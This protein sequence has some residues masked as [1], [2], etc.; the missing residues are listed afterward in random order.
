[1]GG[2]LARVSLPAAVSNVSYNAANQLAQRNG[3]TLTYDANGNLTNDGTLTYAWNARNQL[4]SITGP[5]LSAS[6]AY[7][8]SGRRTAKQIN[9]L[10]WNF[11]F[12]GA[13][14]VQEQSVGYVTAN[15]PTGFGVDETFARTDALGA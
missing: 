4:T 10:H 3:A 7:D 6:F 13:K 9:G 2:S 8:S 5:S 11:L 12:D 14:V 15:L 1:M